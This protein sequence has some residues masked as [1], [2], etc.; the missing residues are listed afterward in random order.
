[1]TEIVRFCAESRNYQEKNSMLGKIRRHSRICGLVSCSQ[2]G[3]SWAGDPDQQ[4]PS[5]PSLLISQ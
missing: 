4:P 2:M 3:S 5:Q 1:V